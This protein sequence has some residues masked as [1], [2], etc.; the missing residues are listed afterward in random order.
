MRPSKSASEELEEPAE[1]MRAAVRRECAARLAR[2]TAKRCEADR[3][4]KVGAGQ[5]SSSCSAAAANRGWLKRCVATTCERMARQ[6]MC[7]D[8]AQKA[9]GREAVLIP[10][11]LLKERVLKDPF[12]AQRNET[13]HRS[14]AI[15]A[16]NLL[17]VY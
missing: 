2:T 7:A 15:F 5:A 11:V 6:V 17:L 12:R 1:D 3:K 16:S 13:H 9:R 8:V 14:V 10:V 4:P